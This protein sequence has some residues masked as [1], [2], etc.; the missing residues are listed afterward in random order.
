M[1]GR[2]QDDLDI[3]LAVLREGTTGRASG[4]VRCSQPTVV[5]RIA[6][7]EETL[8]LRLFERT[9]Q[10]YAPNA[11]ALA[12]APLAEEVAIA[13]RRFEDE[14]G[15]L[16][17]RHDETIRITFLDDFRHQMRP[18]FRR[19]ARDWPEARLD[20]IPTTDMANLL[21]GDADIALRGGPLPVDDRLIATALP[22]P[23]WG[24]Y[25]AADATDV[26]R[27]LDEL[28]PHLIGVLP[29]IARRLPPFA[30]LLALA[31]ENGHSAV[32]YPGYSALISA[33]ASGVAVSALPLAMGDEEAELKR[34][35]VMP[36]AM[37][38]RPALHL[39]GRRSALRRRPVRALY[40]TI[41]VAF[42]ERRA[43]ITG[44]AS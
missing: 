25:V 37:E 16:L 3:F 13:R 43:Q 14:A 15:A 41:I 22:T 32:D 20:L 38:E 31:G 6:A 11:H 5:R 26:P 28:D 34:A 1:G 27:A 9:A 8:G 33:I 12:L 29:G 19:F 18:A 40:D 24:I 30:R 39:V 44:E 4:R 17:A 7:L 21:E 10:G 35:F 42:E 2:V 23:A 36:L